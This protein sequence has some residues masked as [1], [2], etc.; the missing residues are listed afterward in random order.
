MAEGRDWTRS[1]FE[2][3]PDC[4]HDSSAVADTDLPRALTDTAAEWGSLLATAPNDDLRRWSEPGVWSPLEYAC[5]TR[6][7]VAVFDERVRRTAVDPGQQL[8]WWD[9]DA[10]VVD[11]DYNGQVPVLVAEAIA[12]NARAFG[13][14]LSDL[15]ADAWDLAAERR[16]GEHFTIRGMA[17]FVLHELAHHRWDAHGLVYGR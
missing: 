6:D 1:Q 3:C 16:P 8:G 11:D 15:E 7:V 5:H 4:G 14:T 10:A 2:A 12:A 17:R 13:R 9:H